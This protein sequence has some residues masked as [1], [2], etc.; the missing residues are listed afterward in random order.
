MTKPSLRSGTGVSL[1][2]LALFF[3]LMILA[4]SLATFI[5]V[6]DIP[7]TDVLDVLYKKGTPEATSIIMNIRLPRM[8]TGMLAGIHFA[9]AGLLLQSVTRN[10]LADPSIMGVSQGA[11]LAV[12][13]FML[14]AVYIDDPGANTLVE[15]PVSWLPAVGMLGG[16]IAG[17]LVYLLALRY[18][19]GS[20]RITICG[21]AV[22]A[23][24]HAVAIGL[25]AGWGSARVEVLLEWL[26]GSLYAKS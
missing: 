2:I 9:L 14:F 1:G 11:T 13:L 21:I 16:C 20:L 3:L 10:P 4:V 24:L 17:G 8:I 26:S 7:V 19:L 15:L 25:I 18:D 5:G 6:V 22:G 12:T 23:V